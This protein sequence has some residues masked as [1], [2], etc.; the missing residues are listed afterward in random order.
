MSTNLL[1]N[2][3]K[4]PKNILSHGTQVSLVLTCVATTELVM[5]T[6][7]VDMTKGEESTKAQSKILRRFVRNGATVLLGQESDLYRSS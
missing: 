4:Q 6:W 3:F 5:K 1:R 2:F 7:R